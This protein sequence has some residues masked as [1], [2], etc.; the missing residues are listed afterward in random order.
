M[1]SQ[2]FK[3]SSTFLWTFLSNEL[4]WSWCTGTENSWE[5]GES[6]WRF[7]STCSLPCTMG[8]NPTWS[9]LNGD[10]LE[11]KIIPLRNKTWAPCGARQVAALGKEE[12][13]QFMLMVTTTF[14]GEILPFQCIYKG[15]TK[16]SLPYQ[17]VHVEAENA[18]FMF[19]C[20]GDNHWSN[21]ECVKEVT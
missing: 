21:L 16:N 14:S 4:H 13:W 19:S 5:L 18:G 12:K 8:W 10:Q 6:L 7:L 3:C 11:T 15:H 20:G 17:T 1:A 9:N 2:T